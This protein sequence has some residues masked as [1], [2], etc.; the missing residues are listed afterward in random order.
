MT[1]A[2]NLSQ[3]TKKQKTLSDFSTHESKL[4]GHTKE[5]C[6]KLQRKESILKGKTPS[7][8]NEVHT[9]HLSCCSCSFPQHVLEP[10]DLF[11]ANRLIKG[12]LVYFLFDYGNSHNFIN[13]HLV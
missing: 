1:F 5:K 7:D 13:N 10:S 9:Q 8:R 12:S 11:R 4:Q 6:L 2:H 3:F